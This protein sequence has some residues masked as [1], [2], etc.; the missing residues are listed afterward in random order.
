MSNKLLVRYAV[1]WYDIMWSDNIWFKNKPVANK[2]LHFLIKVIVRFA[3]KSFGWKQSNPWSNKYC[4]KSPNA[5]KANKKC[6]N[7]SD[8]RCPGGPASTYSRDARNKR[9]C[10]TCSTLLSF[11]TAWLPY[12]GKYIQLFLKVGSWR[13]F[14]SS[15]MI[16]F[17]YI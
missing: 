16:S 5:K 8:T 2:I 12:S 13:T 1:F 10:R 6:Q 4:S 7:S 11:S 3:L 15:C 17:P 9:E 14:M